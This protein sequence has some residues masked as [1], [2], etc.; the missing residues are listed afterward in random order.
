ME[1]FLNSSSFSGIA[2]L[3]TGLLV[4]VIYY[5]QKKN[6]KMQAA[7]VLLTEIRI[8]EERIGQIREKIDSKIFNDF[9]PV[10]PTKSWKSYSHLFISDFDQ[11]ELRLINLFYDYGELIE[12]YAKR[13][14]EYFWITTQ[15]RAKVQVHEIANIIRDK[16][17]EQKDSD[18]EISQKRDNLIKKMDLHN[19]TYFPVWTID[20]I[21]AYLSKIQT[22]TVSSCGAKLKKLAR[23]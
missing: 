20:Q 6:D 1:N 16:S 9:P 18:K 2:T 14:N 23:V 15:E 22:V 5:I 3:V 10:F 13:N 4:I 11:D 19:T 12:D 21:R 8:A 7:R 17:E